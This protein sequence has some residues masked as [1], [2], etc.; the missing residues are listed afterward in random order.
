[1]KNI[2]DLISNIGDE[3]SL[4]KAINKKITSVT[5]PIRR[6]T[7][8]E[9][10]SKFGPLARVTTKRAAVVDSYRRLAEKIYGTVIDSK[11]TLNDYA[12]ANDIIKQ[13]VEGIVKGARI[14]EEKYYSDGSIIVETIIK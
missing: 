7:L 10:G 14:V 12:I 8:K 4:E 2:E 3:R 13:R 1:M 11:T 9:Y 5:M 6:I